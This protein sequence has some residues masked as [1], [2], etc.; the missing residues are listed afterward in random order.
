MA[1]DFIA[2][3]NKEFKKRFSGFRNNCPLS[4][5]FVYSNQGELQV[6]DKQTRQRLLRHEV[7]FSKPVKTNIHDVQEALRSLYPTFAITETTQRSLTSEEINRLLDEGHS[8]QDVMDFTLTETVKTEYRIDRVLHR[9]NLV[10]LT[11]LQTGE[12]DPYHMSMPVSIFLWEVED[13]SQEVVEGHF[14]RYVKKQK[15]EKCHEQH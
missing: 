14:R 4:I 8:V 1:D 7:D 6:F 10:F 3:F 11:N 5:Q 15:K 2:E 9:K 13:K 12:T